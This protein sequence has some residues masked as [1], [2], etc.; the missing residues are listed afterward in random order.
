MNDP[1]TRRGDVRASRINEIQNEI[2]AIQVEL[3]AIEEEDSEEAEM[4]RA[5]YQ[6]LI[7][8]EKEMDAFVENY[9]NEY[10]EGLMPVLPVSLP[11]LCRSS[12]CTHP[13][14]NWNASLRP[15]STLWLFWNTRAGT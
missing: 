11:R 10:Q 4:K 1:V 14:Q 12:P 3:S 9:D 2:S 6:E 15:R 5:K 7:K 13:V 8:K